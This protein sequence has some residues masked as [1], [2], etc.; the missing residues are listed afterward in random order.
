MKI[1][2]EKQQRGVTR[3][4]AYDGKKLISMVKVWVDYMYFGS[5]VLHCGVVGEVF[6]DEAYRGR[7][8]AKE[9]MLES[10]AWMEKK[11]CDIAFLY[12]IPV[13]YQR[14]GY[15]PVF[16]YYAAHIDNWHQSFPAIDSYRCR[17]YR[18]D[19][20]AGVMKVYNKE[21]K[22]QTGSFR[23]SQKYWQEHSIKVAL[24]STLV[25]VDKNNTVC[26]YA[27][28]KE[29]KS[30]LKNMF[31]ARFMARPNEKESLDIL[32]SA[33]VNKTA[34]QALLHGLQKRS[35]KLEKQHCTVLTPHNRLCAQEIF[36]AG[37][38]LSSA[39]SPGGMQ[40]R[41]INFD[42]AMKKMGKAWQA[43]IQDSAFAT[44][45]A[46]LK[47]KSDMG[48]ISIQVKKGVCDVQTG[49]QGK[50][51]LECTA[52]DLIASLFNY[53]PTENFGGTAGALFTTLCQQDTNCAWAMDERFMEWE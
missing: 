2:L 40:A 26:A 51:D 47:I 36:A 12:G 9:L 6:T 46:Q 10:F 34:A 38:K 45:D 18:N 14:I 20:L 53:P 3:I 23:R 50:A 25:C 35:A 8:L 30:K 37:G 4:A 43:K 24:K 42:Q 1:Q 28:I 31:S 32:E 29:E 16:P 11:Q 15:A 52:Q 44:Q 21:N 48:D 41:F 17:K 33:A 22:G 49:F 19:D 5:A 39:Q 7:G 27:I 13:F